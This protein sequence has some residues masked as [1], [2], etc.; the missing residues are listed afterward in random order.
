MYATVAVAAGAA[1]ARGRSSWRASRERNG[2]VPDR[3]VPDL[4]GPGVRLLSS[5]S[6]RACGP[7]ATQTHFALRATVFYPALRLGGVVDRQL[8]RAGGMTRTTVRTCSPRHRDSPI[9]STGPRSARTSSAAELVAGAERLTALVTEYRPVVVA[10]A[11]VT[12]YRTAFGRPKDAPAASPSAGRCA[13]VGV[14]NPSGLNAHGRF[15]TS[16]RRTPP[17][18][19]AGVIG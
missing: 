5:A 13:G 11:G 10:I 1:A 8:D 17:T 3:S 12:A 15:P 19:A 9:W 14:P 7:A 2:V 4:V 16:R 18:L 6:T